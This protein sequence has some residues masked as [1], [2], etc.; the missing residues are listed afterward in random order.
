MRLCKIM[1]C[2]L[3]LL[4]VSRPLQ[5]Q[6]K[7][8]QDVSESLRGFVQEFY[9]WYLPMALKNTPVPA[10][11]LAL[12]SKSSVFDPQLARVLR[13]DSAAEAKTAGDI[14]GL[15]FDPFLCSQDP[16]ERYEVGRISQKGEKYWVEIYGVWSGKKG[17]KPAVVPELRQKD[18]S[19]LFVN[20]H[21]PED[22][23]LL[24]DLKLLREDRRKAS[25]P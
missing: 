19:W 20:F 25:K 18:G 22:R 12:E 6:A 23:D 21:Y 11:D 1:I 10:W 4:A 8:G 17:E 7:G 15:D 14:V 16:G 3:L 24:T 9:D 13:E 2:C 5:A